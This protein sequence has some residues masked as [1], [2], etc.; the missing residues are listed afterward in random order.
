MAGVC[1]LFLDN[2]TV[3]KALGKNVSWIVNAQESCEG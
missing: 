2:V 3:D 1:F